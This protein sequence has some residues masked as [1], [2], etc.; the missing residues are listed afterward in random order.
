MTQLHHLETA[1]EDRSA[2][3]TAKRR[4]I[5]DRK[6]L[7]MIDAL[8][9]LRQRTEAVLVDLM[10]A[11]S[12][13]DESIEIELQGSPTRDPRDFS[14]PMTARALIARRDNLRATI[15]AISEEM[16]RGSHE[17]L[18]LTARTPQHKP[19]SG[20]ISAGAGMR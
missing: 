7:V 4:A 20:S 6:R 16:A 15:A 1:N 18:R 12:M 17:A 11:A 19:G 13:L 3:A 8:Q 5:E 10:R 9:R 2:R 14:F